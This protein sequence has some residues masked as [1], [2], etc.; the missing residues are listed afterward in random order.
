MNKSDAAGVKRAA[1]RSDGMST[2]EHFLKKF[3]YDVSTPRFLLYSLCD[4]QGRLICVDYLKSEVT[5]RGSFNGVEVHLTN[6]VDWWAGIR[7]DYCVGWL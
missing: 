2:M 4:E 6:W 3:V 7:H 1:E 5:F